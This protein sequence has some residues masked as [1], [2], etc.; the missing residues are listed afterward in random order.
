MAGLSDMV[1]FNCR[2]TRQTIQVN[3]GKVFD[4]KFS[5]KPAPMPDSRMRA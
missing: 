1:A 5:L 2:S 4:R 3:F